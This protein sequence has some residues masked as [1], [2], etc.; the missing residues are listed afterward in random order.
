MNYPPSPPIGASA[1]DR[2]VFQSVAHQ[3]FSA[4]GMSNTLEELLDQKATL[5]RQIS[6]AQRLQRADAISAC[7]ALMAASGLTAADLAPTST[8]RK[9]SN[10]GHKVGSKVAPKYRDPSS[11]STWT[12]RG[13]KPKW[14]AAALLRG[15][16]LID[17]AII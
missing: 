11:G 15:A 9:G 16:Q 10:A 1:N 8:K 2:V 4:Q 12:G 6:E 13:L 7:L 3:L 17:F 5:E 14:M